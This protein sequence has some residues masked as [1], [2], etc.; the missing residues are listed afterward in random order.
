M[1]LTFVGLIFGLAFAI[2]SS[3]DS[4]IKKARTNT[5]TVKRIGAY[6]LLIVGV[7]TLTLAIFADFFGT[8]FPV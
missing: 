5:R 2:A 3:Q 7:W 4:I 6:M 8:I 1:A